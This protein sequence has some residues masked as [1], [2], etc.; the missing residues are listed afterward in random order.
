MNGTMIR[1]V[2]TA[3]VE[4]IW[5]TDYPGFNKTH[6]MQIEAKSDGSFVT[7]VRPNSSGPWTP[8]IRGSY[9][10]A[11]N[12]TPCVIAYVNINYASGT[13]DWI[14]WGSLPQDIKNVFGGSNEIK[15]AVYGTGPTIGKGVGV[16]FTKQQQ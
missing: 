1:L 4:G 15:I 5:T 13:E 6:Y 8:L 9:T 7:S 16:I 2:P 3:S 14:A 12:P 11:V 10:K